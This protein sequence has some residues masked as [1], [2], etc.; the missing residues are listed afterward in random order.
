VLGAPL[1]VRTNKGVEPTP[2]ALRFAERARALLDDADGLLQETLGDH[3]APLGEVH[4]RFPT[5]IPPVAVQRLLAALSATHPEITLR[6]DTRA[7][8][9]ADLDPSVDV[10]VHFGEAATTGTFRTFAVRN[11]K[12]RLMASS[13]YLESRGRPRSAEELSHH[14]LLQ[15][16]LHS[17][18]QAMLPLTDGGSVAMAPWFSS[19]DAFIV[20]AAADAGH[21]VAL[22]PE[23]L[24]GPAGFPFGPLEVVLPDLVAI[25]EVVRILIPERSAGTARTQAILELLRELGRAF[26]P[27]A[28]S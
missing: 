2:A 7:N 23:M 6:L 26:L 24:A 8:P 15:W 21:G 1:L 17:L 3:H 16:T 10:V 13:S 9:L 5:G 14:R 20:R 4:V 25:E 11:F 19:P 27:S 12:L 28:P 18:P 22:L